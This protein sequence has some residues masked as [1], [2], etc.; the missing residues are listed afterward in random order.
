M[1]MTAYLMLFVGDACH[2]TQPVQLALQHAQEDGVAHVQL[3][4]ARARL[5]DDGALLAY[6][7][8]VVQAWAECYILPVKEW[9]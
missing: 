1:M 4:S 2:G 6:L 7:Q 3:L 9:G 8:H 5:G